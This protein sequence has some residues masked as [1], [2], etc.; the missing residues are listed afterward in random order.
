MKHA[1]SAEK[2]ARSPICTADQLACAGPDAIALAPPAYGIDVVDQQAVPGLAATEPGV[3]QGVFK[4]GKIPGA[5]WITAHIPAE[6]EYDDLATHSTEI[7]DDADFT[8]TMRGKILGANREYYY[9]HQGAVNAHPAPAH[10]TWTTS[11][12]S[13]NELYTGAEL[14]NYVAQVDHIVPYNSWGSND[15]RNARVLSASENVAV[16]TS[17]PA[18]NN[19]RLISHENRNV[20]GVHYGFEEILSQPK[21]ANLVDEAEDEYT[22]GAG[23][24]QPDH[25]A[26]FGATAVT[27]VTDNDMW[28]MYHNL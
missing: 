7:H 2:M 10:G 20:N 13:G 11:D 4:I 21:V 24:H 16:G 8:A 6:D 25:N 26:G 19:F 22:N 17:R 3:V 5:A 27:A 18:V 9:A 14:H 28:A 15:Y 1:P 12:E 23:Q